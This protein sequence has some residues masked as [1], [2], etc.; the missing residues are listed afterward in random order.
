[1][2]V[3]AVGRARA[4]GLVSALV[5]LDLDRFKAVNDSYGHAAGDEVLRVVA[6]RL[7]ASARPGDLLARQGGDEFLLLM[8]DLDAGTAVGTALAV[9]DRVR[10]AMAD[11][12]AL[13]GGERVD[14]RC[15]VGVSLLGRDAH[16]ADDLLQHADV[17]MYRAK[18]AGSGV[19]LYQHTGA[20]TAATEAA[21]PAGAVDPA[22]QAERVAALDALLAGEGPAAVF[23]PIVDLD[24]GEVVAYEA[25]ARGT[26][27]SP[28]A[29]PDQLFGAARAAGRLGE[30][31]WACRGAALRAARAA[32]LTRPR[33]L[34]VNVEP[35]A[36]DVPCPPA[37]AE[38]WATAS[39]DVDVVVEITERALTARPADL[40]HLVRE[41]RARG[42]AIAL[43][44]VGADVR[45]LAL[46]PLLRPDVIK[47]DLRLVQ[48]QPTTEVAEIVNAVNAQR[49]RTGAVVLA[50]GI[51]TEEH[52]ATARALGA[53]VG[54]GWL[55][56]RPGP[57]APPAEP[58][59]RPLPV[60]AAAGVD[61]AVDPTAVS[62]FE[63]VRAVREVRR[64]DKALLLAMSLQLEAQ[65]AALGET[66]VVASA[67]Q[68]AERFTPLTHR[69]YTLMA[70]DT[71]FV[72]ALGVGMA[73]EPAPGV[74]GAALAEDDPLAGEWSVAILGPHFAAALVAV[75]L[76]DD[77]PEM[78]RRFDF[79]LTYD[80]DLVIAAANALMRRIEPLG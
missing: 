15:S 16:D 72:A 47:L 3:R 48:D 40:L 33:K 60:V 58:P 28:V 5:F 42:W 19:K 63:V 23:Q 12:I 49:E 75:D 53:S 1:V 50:E 73:P 65:A 45:S 80:R 9:A 46:M 7:R 38:E 32:G 25:L 68:S 6:Q 52:L 56:G 51:E 77:G 69:R 43:D 67:F 55:F 78:S 71:A 64:A 30:L 8:A 66:A 74:R 70:A 31:D 44:D 11:P 26:A 27:G 24:S 22:E 14:M 79:A 21:A 54:Q 13:P 34:F 2:L 37:L 76:G 10:L 57:L 4:H 18:R 35:D 61:D 17:A 39:D 36:L 59:A 20:G 41:V 29:R 62:P